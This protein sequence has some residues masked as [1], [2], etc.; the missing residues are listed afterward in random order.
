MAITRANILG[1]GVESWK[2]KWGID[3]TP[4]DAYYSLGA[5][6]DASVRVDVM[7]G[8]SGEAGENRPTWCK[9]EATAK[10]LCTDKTTV[11]ELLHNLGN[12]YLAHKITAKNGTTFKGN[13]GMGWRFDSSS[14]FGGNRFIE[15]RAVH[16]F[17]LA[18]ASLEDLADVLD[19]PAADGTPDAG[20]VLYTWSAATKFPAGV[21][22]ITV[23]PT[24][25]PAH[26]GVYNN[27]RFIAECNMTSDGLG[28]NIGNNTIRLTSE[29][30]C[31]QTYTELALMGSLIVATDDNVMTLADGTVI[32]M[33]GL[34]YPL[35]VYTLPSGMENT[36]TM[37]YAMTKV[38]KSSEWAGIVS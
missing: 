12:A 11:L 36:A 16:N 18:H 10:M 27:A 29:F 6:A 17:L 25:S 7:Q 3:E 2:V 8:L 28:R 35:N 22:T 34:M 19:T 30:D 23:D 37:R 31:L 24:G 20:D 1:G 32:T 26:P 15:V 4:D 9:L 33:S 38:I 13:F 21:T 14:D 5:L